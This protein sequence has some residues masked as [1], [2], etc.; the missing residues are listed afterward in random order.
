PEPDYRL[1]ATAPVLN[2]WARCCWSGTRAFATRL[3]LSIRRRMGDGQEALPIVYIPLGRA[4][5]SER[6]MRARKHVSAIL[7]DALHLKAERDDDADDFTKLA[8]VRRAL[9]VRRTLVIFDGVELSAEPF[10]KLFDVIKHTDWI[11][12]F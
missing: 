3:A 2:I 8:D 5:T 7:R 9:S 6:T 11:P 10:S 1:S 12:Y 4:L